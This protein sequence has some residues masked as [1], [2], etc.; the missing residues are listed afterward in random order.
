MGA[1]D[2]DGGYIRLW[3]FMGIGY[4][5]MVYGLNFFGSRVCVDIFRVFFNKKFC[6]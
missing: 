3:D 1:G 4:R 6:F 5:F 2:Y